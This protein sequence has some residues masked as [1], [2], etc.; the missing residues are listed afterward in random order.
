LFEAES[1][2]FASDG[3][4]SDCRNQ[5]RL[6]HFAAPP[7][8]SENRTGL[9]DRPRFGSRTIVTSSKD[10]ASTHRIQIGLTGQRSDL[11]ATHLLGVCNFD[12]FSV[13]CVL[14]LSLTNSVVL[15]GGAV[16]LPLSRG[17][18]RHLFI[19]EPFLPTPATS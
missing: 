16:A 14:Y 13:G 9:S 10:L 7:N 6:F 3:Q 1:G 17:E 11:A 18:V 8:F 5:R 2:L 19:T 15:F 12:H 4:L